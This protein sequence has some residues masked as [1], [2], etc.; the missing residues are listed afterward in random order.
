MYLV[1]VSSSVRHEKIPSNKDSLFC[2]LLRSDRSKAWRTF[3]RCAKQG[4]GNLFC[5]K[6]V[7]LD[8][9]QTEKQTLLSLYS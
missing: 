9:C 4:V 7:P 8:Y 6:S 5:L 2:T 1:A 3:R